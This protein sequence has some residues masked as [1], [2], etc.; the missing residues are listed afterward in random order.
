MTFV[1]DP[2]R[3]WVKLIKHVN[4]RSELC[5]LF[6]GTQLIGLNGTSNDFPGGDA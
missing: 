5:R 3:L 6:L 4:K 1:S 2:K